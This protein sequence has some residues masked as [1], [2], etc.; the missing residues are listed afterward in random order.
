MPDAVRMWLPPG[1]M[2]P[3]PAIDSAEEDAGNEIEASTDDHSTGESDDIV[4]DREWAEELAAEVGAELVFTQRSKFPTCYA[5]LKC[6]TV[7][8][9]EA[10]KKK[11]KR[12]P[13]VAHLASSHRPVLTATFRDISDPV[14]RLFDGDD[15]SAD[16]ACEEGLSDGD[17][18]LSDEEVLEH[19][20]QAAA[21]EVRYTLVYCMHYLSTKTY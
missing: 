2:P 1:K 12:D 17:V 14:D 20:E 16:E 21:F 11:N 3:A 7:F 18:V 9:P 13:T 6:F 15:G 5:L 19:S 8:L 10:S 4:I